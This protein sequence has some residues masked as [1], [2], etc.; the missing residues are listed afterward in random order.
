MIDGE[1]A[2]TDT[3][4]ERIATKG[5]AL[6]EFIPLH[7]AFCVKEI[8]RLTAELALIDERFPPAGEVGRG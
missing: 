3:P 5:T 4:R 6:A 1:N 2:V 7:R 8:E